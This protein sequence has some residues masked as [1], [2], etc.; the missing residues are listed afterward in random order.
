VALVEEQQEAEEQRQSA[1]SVMLHL[2]NRKLSV[3]WNAWVAFASEQLE[4]LQLIR[5]CLNFMANRKLAQAFMS[6]LG[7][8]DEEASSYSTLDPSQP[9]P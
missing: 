5:R 3:G 1:R 7:A 2:A 4:A 9:Q 6:W 8:V